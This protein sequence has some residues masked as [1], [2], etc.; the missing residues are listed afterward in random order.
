[1]RHGRKLLWRSL[2]GI[3][4]LA[5]VGALLV[6]VW[7]WSVL[8]A[9]AYDA[10]DL[11]GAEASWS[12]QRTLTTLWP[13]PWKAPYNQGTGR[14][15]QGEWTEAVEPLRAALVRVPVAPPD[16]DGRLDPASPECRVRTNLAAAL[17]GVAAT[18]PD[19]AA[20]EAAAAEAAEVRG[21]CLPD[22]PDP[23]PSPTEEPPT[24]T[25]EPG[26]ETP[27]DPRLEE[28]EERNQRAR[29]EAEQQQQGEGGG[30]GGGQNW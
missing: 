7:V 3:A 13:E 10:G 28:L 11:A 27:S 23:E 21:P 9:R 17:D 30:F 5:T 25:P 15:A 12:R 14:L 4:L 26:E 8:A 18:A 6:L 16:E 1:M 29:E 24:P 22:E 2:P 20:G 19:A